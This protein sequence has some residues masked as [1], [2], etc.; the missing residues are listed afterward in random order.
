MERS[1]WKWAAIGMSV[2]AFLS[3]LAVR[4][5]I[6]K[7]GSKKLSLRKIVQSSKCESLDLIQTEP[8]RIVDKGFPFIVRLALARSKKPVLGTIAKTN[9]FL[10][11]YEPGIF[12]TSVGEYNLLFN[13]YPVVPQHVLLVTK[14]FQPQTDPLT[15]ADFEVAQTVMKE[16]RALVFYNSGEASGHSQPHKHL[17]IIPLDKIGEVPLLTILNQHSTHE[18][19]ALPQFQFQHRVQKVHIDATPAELEG[20]YRGLFRELGSSPSASYNLLMT[21]DWIFL[22]LREKE[23]AFEKASF[24]ALAFAGLMLVKDRDD[25]EILRKIGPLTALRDISVKL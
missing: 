9:P 16:L 25:L 23:R 4:H 21:Q 18:S 11:P 7:R 12:L 14:Q 3:V 15:V 24:N 1:S 19:F 2:G 8:H 6:K 5:F 13:K 22:V 17:Q 10:Y 20:L